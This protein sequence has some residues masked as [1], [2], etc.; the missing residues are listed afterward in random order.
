MNIV[1]M[2]MK[3]FFSFLNSTLDST[4]KRSFRI[5]KCINVTFMEEPKKII[6]V[7]IYQIRRE[8]VF[9]QKKEF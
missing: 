6:K 3:L 5:Y 1:E 9:L 7:K 8:L 4:S 2:V